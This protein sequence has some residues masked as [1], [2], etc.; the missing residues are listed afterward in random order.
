MITLNEAERL[1]KSSLNALY[2]TEELL[3][4]MRELLSETTGMNRTRLL[5][6]D[7]GTFLS[8]E[9]EDKLRIFV[10][11]MQDGMPLQYAVGHAPFFGREFKVSPAVLIP[12]PETEELAA[13][14]LEK[15]KPT[16]LPKL[17]DIGTGSG[18]LAITLAE[19][20]PANTWAVDV[21]PEALSIARHNAEDIAQVS[22][23]EAD[24]LS[25][26]SRW[27]TLE[28]MDII[29]SNPPYIMPSEMA[30]MSRS[31]VE[32]EPSLALFAPASDPLLFYRAIAELAESGK[33]RSGG[34]IYLELNALLADDTLSLFANR[35]GWEQ[36]LL[37]HDLSGK[38]RFL[39]AQYTPSILK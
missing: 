12:R 36:I 3:C 11:D 31:V 2:D 9:A 30:Q 27:D 23:F 4:I 16:T 8:S 29:V 37:H 24:I 15:E 39:S 19:K 17:L 13:L 34:R 5:L 22:F 14:I 33:L 28:P 35:E 25:L 26:D 1:I 7:K 32:H 21:S 18:C 6:T 20:L 38:K 10:Q